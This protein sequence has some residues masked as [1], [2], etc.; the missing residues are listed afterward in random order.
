MPRRGELRR[1]FNPFEPDP[2]RINWVDSMVPG[3]ASGRAVSGAPAL[4][5]FQP[6]AAG[7]IQAY[8]FSASTTNSVHGSIQLNHDYDENTVIEMHLHQALPDA[9]SGTVIWELQYTWASRGEAFP[10]RKTITKTSNAPRVA[11]QHQYVDLGELRPT[12]E[13]KTIS[14][15]VMFRLARLGGSDSYADV[16]Y[17]LSLDAHYKANSFGS[18]QEGRK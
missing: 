4:T 16:A 15:I 6:G 11:F 3:T 12:G 7:D 17:L 1:L 5:A 10:T 18:R 2:V 8:A 14:S 13:P 9:T